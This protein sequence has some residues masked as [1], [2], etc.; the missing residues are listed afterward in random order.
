MYELNFIMGVCVGK[1]FVRIGFGAVGLSDIPWGSWNVT[2]A[3]REGTPAFLAINHS[4]TL[5]VLGSS[6]ALFTH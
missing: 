6:L 5:G 3:D 1:T 4:V 2:P